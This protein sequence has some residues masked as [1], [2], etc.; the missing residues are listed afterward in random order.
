MH[1]VC[2]EQGTARGEGFEFGVVEFLDNEAGEGKGAIPFHTLL[3]VSEQD[4]PKRKH[5]G[6]EPAPMPDLHPP[7]KGRSSRPSKNGRTTQ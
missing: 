6:I 4:A 3:A 1:V 5:W 2:A 7:T